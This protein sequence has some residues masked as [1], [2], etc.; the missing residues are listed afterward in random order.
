VV[1]SRVGDVYILGI[2]KDQ[3]KK[4]ELIEV[5]KKKSG[6]IHYLNMINEQYVDARGI[7]SGEQPIQGSALKDLEDI[8]FVFWVT[9]KWPEIN[10]YQNNSK[11]KNVKIIYTQNLM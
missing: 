6:K 7:S 9:K 10:Q 5:V 8:R 4:T 11:F 1:N 2:Q 3:I